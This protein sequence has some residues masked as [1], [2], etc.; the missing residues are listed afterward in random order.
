M[1][2]FLERLIVRAATVD[3]L[4]SDD[5]EAMPGQKEDADPAA[6]RLAAWCH[7]SASGDWSLFARRLERDELSFG[8]VL[9]KFATVRHSRS[10][11][12]PAW[13]DDAVWIEAALRNP[14][15]DAG[16]AAPPQ[17][18]PCAFEHLMA[19]AVEHAEAQLWACVDDSARAILNDS[20]RACLRHSLL[21]E[22]CN[23]CAAAIYERFVE[24]R[25]AASADARETQRDGGTAQYD[26]FVADM[27]RDGFRILFDDKP[28]LLRLLASITRQW[29]ET[30]RDFVVRLNADLSTIRRDIL[31]GAAGGRV[32]RIE[33]SLSDPHNG[34]YS[35]LIVHFEDGSRVVYKPKDVRLDAAW[36][37]L[38]GR[39]NRS[40]A[41]LELK[42]VRV[43]ACDGYGWTEFVEHRGCADGES[44]RRFFRRAGAWLALFHGFAGTDMHQENMI[45]AGEHPVPIDLEMI[46]Q[47]TDPEQ[48]TAAIEAQA[49]QAATE[50][51][52]NS[53]LM[54]GLVPAYGRSPDN[55]VFARGGLTSDWT[56]RTK[57][58]W[59][60]INS[61]TMRPTK[62]KEAGAT[63]PNLP[64]VGGRYAKFGDHIDD[65]VAGFEDYARFLLLL[66][67]DASQGGLFDGFAGLAVRKVIRP[68]RFYYMLLQRLRNHRTMGDGVT[69]SAQA[70]FLARLADWD[71]SADLLWPLQRAERAA[72]VELNVP[73]F[74]SPSDGKEI[75]DAEGASVSSEATPG[76][77]RA[78]ARVR[79]FDEREVA[80]QVEVIRQNTATVSRS[81]D[82]GPIATTPVRV[83]RSGAA[84]VPDK[85]LFLAEADKIAAE[86]AHYA[87]RKGPAAAWIGLD[88]L[89]D[90]E[91]VQLV[92]LGADLYNGVGGIA[93]FLA[94]HAATTGS[95][96]SKELAMA[97]VAHPRKMLRGRNAA[98]M[99]RALGV[100]GATGLGSI[101]Y[102][103]AVMARCLRDDDLLADA[104]AAAKLFSDDLIAADKQLDVI[105]GCAGGILG[106]L[107]LH[108]DGPSADVLGRAVKCGEHLLAQPR[109]GENGGSFIG[110]GSGERPLNG[111]SH[112]AAGFAYALASLAAATGRGDFADAA[113]H[114]IAFEDASYDAQRG[115]W[116][117]LRGDQGSTWTCQWCHGA[118]GIG[119]ARAAGAKRGLMDARLLASDVGLALAGVERDWPGRV[120]TL[121]CGTLGSIELFCEAADALGR[122]E[123]RALASQRLAAVIADAAAGGD[124]RWNVGKRQFNLGLF[125]GLAGVGYTLLRQADCALPNVLIWE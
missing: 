115:N 35:V 89:G 10:A 91:A 62:T 78:R 121:C 32:A 36:H 28:V 82:T 6:R 19:P 39:L 111:M 46:L 103:F 118:I 9:A 5:F 93:L 45:A 114:C 4:L 75:C 64:H 30:S 7:S 83:L 86:L 76:L 22:Q 122:R 120:D 124:Y 3:E 72:L 1:D 61:D 84:I 59:S 112:G 70:D 57:L 125:R 109:R 69:W 80:W 47:A 54:V 26:R 42:A 25:R 49:F 55:K 104:H 48:Q 2:A 31:H 74:V 12:V 29:I 52:D 14:R 18:E 38:V 41:P 34:G 40:G 81:E 44:C 107:R 16:I 92:P 110:Q 79:D 77:A 43:I 11:P 117:D 73:H 66:S 63:V 119:L 23:L 60:N 67:R 87:I 99:A 113:A 21:K 96:A 8:E 71:R 27:R 101:V 85:M 53:V 100:G 56:S 108:R 15:N 24:A 98:R 94:A 65:F 50:I 102:A 33:C 88:W 123:L 90:S 105:G 116:P 68:T 97:A 58:A 95:E 20:A 106:L 17:A 51:V 13:I 37:A